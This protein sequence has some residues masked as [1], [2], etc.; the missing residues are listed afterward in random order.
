MNRITAHY[1]AETAFPP[2][3]AADMMAGEQSVGTFVRVSG[4]TPE[5]VAAVRGARGTPRGRR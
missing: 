2:Q 1:L 4:E 5:R 3:Q